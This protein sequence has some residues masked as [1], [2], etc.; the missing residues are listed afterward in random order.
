MRFIVAVEFEDGSFGYALREEE[1][2]PDHPLV[3]YTV[4]KEEASCFRIDEVGDALQRFLRDVIRGCRNIKE[5]PAFE[6]RV[7]SV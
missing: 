6:F 1:V 7:I 2:D 4:E 5:R 3:W